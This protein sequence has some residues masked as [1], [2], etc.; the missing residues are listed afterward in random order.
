M[1]TAQEIKADLRST[2]GTNAVNKQQLMEYLGLRTY[3]KLN[4]VF[5]GVP[6]INLG[7]QKVYLITDAAQQ[8]F[9]M[10]EANGK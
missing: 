2:Y 10:Q 7:K 3:D 5:R 9:K 6:Y 1:A 8:I 4:E